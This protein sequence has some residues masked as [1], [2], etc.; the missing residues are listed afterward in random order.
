[1]TTI[2]YIHGFNSSPN[3]KTFISL[4][5]GMPHLNVVSLEYDYINPDRSYLRLLSQVE[6]LLTEDPDIVFVGT[7]LGA[8]W[9]HYLSVRFNA[10]CVLVNPSI[11]PSISLQKY[12]GDNV[13]YATGEIKTLTLS[14]CLS[15]KKY[16]EDKTLFVPQSRTVVVLGM[17]D[18]VLDPIAT[19]TYFK[20]AAEIIKIEDM[21]HRVRNVE[22]LINII[23]STLDNITDEKL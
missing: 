13:N 16:E 14:N 9:A 2:A 15:Y 7:S 5:E 18:D 23:N 6:K 3:T 19:E 12:I 10:T 20:D 4:K 11:H 17:K 1:M 8:F 22:S 21:G